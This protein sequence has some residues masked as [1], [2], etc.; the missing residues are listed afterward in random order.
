MSI[1]DSRQS[2]DFFDSTYR[3]TPPWDI[4]QPQPALMALL[5]EYPPAGPV[6]DVGCGTGE[7]ALALAQRGFDVLGLDLA[8][9]AIAQARAKAATAAP[10]A[11]RLVEFRVGDALH[12]ALFPGPFGAVVDSGFFHLFGPL[13]REHFAHELAATLAA[14][15]RY[16]LLG[17]A[18]ASPVP[19]AP[20]QVLESELRALF[21][22]ERGWRVLALRPA[23]FLIRSARGNDVSAI[24]A[25]I[26]RAPLG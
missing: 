26:E 21:A 10:G 3:E 14:G 23:R 18:I 4:G 24:A 16:Y 13:E 7:L 22:P 5:D 8:E 15:G 25:C 9:A 19:N 20:R 12:P 11:G 2:S 1:S 17:F 6:L